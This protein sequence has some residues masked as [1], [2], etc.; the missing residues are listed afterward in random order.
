MK[1]MHTVLP[2]IV[3][4]RFLKLSVRK[5]FECNTMIDLTLLFWSHM[6]TQAVEAL[7]VINPA[8]RNRDS[9]DYFVTTAK[10]NWK[11]W[12]E[13]KNAVLFSWSTELP[14]YNV[15]SLS[16]I[17]PPSQSAYTGCLPFL[18][19]ILYTASCAGPWAFDK[20]S[21]F[22]PR[23]EASQ[24]KALRQADKPQQNNTK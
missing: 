9:P 19:E 18:A 24:R 21:V 11:H 1:Q 20:F 7:S 6:L 4:I 10:E 23:G 15:S 16:R 14:K 8:N 5:N 17:E 22:C 13:N 3:H 2:L 12:G